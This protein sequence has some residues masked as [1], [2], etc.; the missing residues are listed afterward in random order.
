M[1]ESH[2]PFDPSVVMT[3]VASAPFAI[4]VNNVAPAPNSASSGWAP[5]VMTDAGVKSGPGVMG[6]WS[7]CSG[8]IDGGSYL[9]VVPRSAVE[10]L[11]HRICSPGR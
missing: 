6:G 9:G 11:L 10:P 2:D 4:H 3:I 8:D 1:R 7:L 5:I